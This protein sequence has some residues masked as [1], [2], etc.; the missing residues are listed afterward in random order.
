MGVSNS[1]ERQFKVISTGTL[2]GGV[3]K[4]NLIFNLAGMIAEELLL[5]KK[6]IKGLF[7]GS[8]IPEIAQAALL[9]S[10]YVIGS[11]EQLLTENQPA[12]WSQLKTLLRVILTKV[13]V[14][15]EIQ[16][17]IFASLLVRNRVEELLRQNGQPNRILLLDADPQFNLTNNIG[18]DVRQTGL[19]TARDIFET[20]ASASEIIYSSPIKGLPNIDI[21]P[22]SLLL[23]RT[24]INLVS[25]TGREW[26]VTNFISD[27]FSFLNQRYRYIFADTNP[28]LY[29]INQNVFLAA[30]NIIIV[31]DVS[32]NS[33]SGAEFF[34]ALW[35]EIKRPL[36]KADNFG[37]IVINK[38]D[39]RASKRAKG[40]I[41]YCNDP[42]NEEIAKL[43]IKENVP[44]N[45]RL[46]DTETEHLPIN[47]L[48]VKTSSEKESKEKAMA[49]YAKVIAELK[50]RGVL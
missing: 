26:L 43:L 42:T 38:Y 29:M 19:K 15:E 37:A 39:A 18:I 8:K 7:D 20:D 48:P 23:T 11:V 49:A 45:E 12:N 6:I 27:N 5:S 3:G 13:E 21:I 50:E 28:N 34:M 9:A 30:D 35:S 24:E 25:R 31:S 46:A 33:I 14:S 17:E 32:Y 41:E 36:K 1:L 40:F 2:K 16:N 4:S 10:P 44:L 47:I 22:A